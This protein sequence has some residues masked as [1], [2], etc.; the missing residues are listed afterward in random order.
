MSLSEISIRRPVFAWMLMF[1]LIVFGWIS[2]QRMGISQ[3]P[4]VNFPVVNIALQLDGAAPEV[5]EADV[6]DIIEDAVMG[7][8]GL[9]SVSSSSSQGIANITCEFNMDHNIDVALQE[10]QDRILQVNNQLPTALYPPVI[11]KTNPEDQPIMWVMV[12]A[13][14]KVPL[15]QQMMYARN[16]LKDQLSTIDGVGAVVLG[17]YVDPNLR[18]W[19]DREKLKGSELTSSDIF[20]AIQS[21]QNEQPA[22]RIEAP[23]KEMN[24][25]ILGEA[26]TPEDFGKIR[27]NARGGAIN[28]KSTP[29]N[30]VATIE[31]G[32]SDIRA[33]SR[34]NGKTAVGLGIIKQHGSNAV[35][36]SA[37]IYAKV[38][39]MK[40]SLLSGYSLDVRLDST[41]FI[42][43]SVEELNMTLLVAAILTS[44]VCYLF[45]GSWSS[46]FN[47]LLAIPTSIVGA[48]TALY[49]LG[50]TLN[51]FTLLGLSLAI[52][53]VVDDAIMMLENIVRHY[54]MGKTR[55]QAALDGSNEI[56][57]AAIATTLAIAAIFMPVIFM[58]GVVGAFFYQ[59]GI[60]V[61]VAV[62]LS[63]LEAVTLTPMRCARFMHS[64]KHDPTRM[65]KFIDDIMDRLAHSYKRSLEFILQ[66]RKTV[67][68][69]SVILF[70]VSLG[71]VSTLPKEL[72]PA[73]DQGYFLLNIKTPV[74][75]SI[76]STD[77]TFAKVEAYLKTVPEVTDFYTTI[78]NYEHDNIVNAGTIYVILKDPK[79]RKATQQELMQTIRDGAAKVEPNLEVFAQDMSLTGFSASRG[80]PVEF[81]LEGP[82]WEKLKGYSEQILA[83]LRETGLV[84]DINMDYQDGM[85]EIQIIPNR[86]KAAERGI[87]VANISQ[88][89]ETMIGGQIFSANTEYPKEGHR[90]YIRVRA[91]PEQ[92]AAVEDINK[93]YVRN[94]RGEVSPIIGA[95]TIVPTKAPQ[96]ITRFN[97]RRAIPVFANVTPGK[98]QQDALDAV[99]KISKDILPP[100]YDVKITGSGSA[101]Q[102]AFDG[103][104]FALLMGIAV[105]YLILASQFNSFIHPVTILMALP[106]SLTGALLALAMAHQSLSLFSMIGL[107]LL[108]GIVKKNSILLVDFTNQ[109]RAE[110]VGVT[111]ALLDACPVRLRPIL[112]TSIAT[113]AGAI[114]EALN[115]GPGAE[116]RIPMA[117][118]LIGGVSVSTFLTLYVVPCVYSL[119]SKFERPEVDEEPLVKHA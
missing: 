26:K 88:E 114:P 111:E 36:V 66:W 93:L 82:D 33:I 57:F 107:I 17:G 19:L 113:V 12:T 61:T 103:L 75:T 27:I 86:T 52:G 98:S 43:D 97:R 4:D 99:D 53:I 106:F 58:K 67:V 69:G 20:S 110:G 81:T 29:L 38:K 18:V 10:V 23:T 85:N 35:K 72:I 16:T 31:E 101:F 14:E 24:I 39:Q 41:K 102:E 117:I 77:K 34:Y 22:G 44:I 5:M 118:S 65:S 70:I 71:F 68:L 73:Q 100:G 76:V 84:K 21:E 108:M 37:A 30:Q 28:Y 96:V 104:I 3:M 105:A 79:K 62:F 2:F 48:F 80:F 13:D 15:Y 83:K 64:A 119:F 11:T 6:V 9:K 56:T 116:T 7:I 91:K 46:T 112:M 50:F 92:T 49:F 32:L 94:N 89:V 8:E 55:R 60:T 109:R 47:V 95:A 25:R 115:F 87:P 45:L 78:G 1:G 90:Y 51:T 54:E 63:L 42:K 74:G 59:Y 40:V